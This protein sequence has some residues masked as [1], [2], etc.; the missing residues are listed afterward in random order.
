MSLT[1]ANVYGEP[2]GDGESFPYILK[3]GDTATGLIIFD[4][5]LQTNIGEAVFNSTSEFNDDVTLTN[6]A[7]LYVSSVSTFANT[8]YITGGQF[9]CSVAATFSDVL[10]IS[11]LSA[12]LN[13]NSRPI[14]NVGTITG[15]PVFTGGIDCIGQLVLG[16]NTSTDCISI[17]P[18]ASGVQLIEALRTDGVT[19][20]TIDFYTPT[21]AGVRTYSARIDSTGVHTVGTFDTLNQTGTTL[22]IGTAANRSSPINIGTGAGNSKTIIIGGQATGAVTT[23]TGSTTNINSSANGTVAIGSITTTGTINLGALTTTG[24]INIGTNSGRTTGTINIGNASSIGPIAITGAVSLTGSSVSIQTTGTSNTFIGNGTG[25]TTVTGTLNI[26]DNI[27]MGTSTADLIGPL[28]VLTRPFNISTSNA[29][30]LQSSY[31]E[32]DNTIV[33]AYLGGSL[34]SNVSGGGF[35]SATLRYPFAVGPVAPYN[36]S[37]GVFLQKGQYMVYLSVYLNDALAFNT[38]DMIIALSSSSTL[39][40][41]ST[42]QQIVDSCPNPTCYF[43]KTDDAT[44]AAAD[45]ECRTLSGIFYN[46]TAL[47]AT[48]YPIAKITYSVAV[49]F[50]QVYCVFVKIGV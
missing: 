32:S 36:A 11:G 21:T 3:T 17:T 16:S 50:Y 23:I 20:P 46:S 38:T 39:T 33:G 34:A 47:G 22:N 29:Y 1:N 4:G 14:N 10:N 30:A 31:S 2:G 25:T 24:T 45:T 44:A 15:N 12:S 7:T 26:N 35:A 9:F 18:Q 37:G 8:M 27:T 40:S 49:S 28:G 42:D 43:R 41:A 6:L 48:F 13:M 19:L 5:G